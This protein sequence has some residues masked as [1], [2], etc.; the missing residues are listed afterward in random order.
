MVS[1]LMGGS[2]EGLLHDA[3]E[4]YVGD[5]PTPLKMILP[6]FNRLA[7]RVDKKVRAEFGLP[8]E[9]SA[10]CKTADLVALMIEARQLTKDKGRGFSVQKEHLLIADRLINEEPEK[11]RISG[12]KNPTEIETVFIREYGRLTK[13]T[14]EIP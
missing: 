2:L 11:Y 9:K 3:E 4:A 8:E 6:D 10:F 14:K 1:K 5:M 7:A 12:F 13:P